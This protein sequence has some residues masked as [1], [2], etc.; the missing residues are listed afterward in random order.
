VLDTLPSRHA[1]PAS[2]LALYRYEGKLVGLEISATPRLTPLP[3]AAPLPSSFV[4][5]DVLLDDDG[6]WWAGGHA[7]RDE[8]IGQIFTST[9][10][11]S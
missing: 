7:S 3:F 9:D 4:L 11:A 1:K 8:I 2:G 6:R 10:G 5:K